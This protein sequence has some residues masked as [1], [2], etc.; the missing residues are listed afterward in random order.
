METCHFAALLCLPKAPLLP[1]CGGVP[2]PKSRRR[3]GI[4]PGRTAPRPT[5]RIASGLKE[6]TPRVARVG[7]EHARIWKL[8]RFLA[9]SALVSKSYLR[10]STR[11]KSLLRE[12][13]PP[14]NEFG[15]SPPGSVSQRPTISPPRHR[16]HHHQRRR[17]RSA[18]AFALSA[19]LAHNLRAFTLSHH[20]K[21][22]WMR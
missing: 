12:L 7:V 4:L 14:A 21:Q 6:W 9:I 11:T 2:A 13:V 20:T 1:E 22:H 16:R 15:P 3:P 18:S 8:L 10:P 19:A 17:P 5:S